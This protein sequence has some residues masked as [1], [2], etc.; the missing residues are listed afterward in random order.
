MTAGASLGAGASLLGALLVLGITLP[1]ADAHDYGWAIATAAAGAILAPVTI[2]A[3]V[4]LFGNLSGLGA[5]FGWTLLGS[6]LGLLP[7][8]ALFLVGLLANDAPSLIIIG[9]VLGGVG[10]MTGSIIAFEVSSRPG[11]GSGL[12]IGA[13]VGSLSLSGHFD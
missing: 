6:L 13:G 9:P 3:G 11:Q 1:A 8:A 5:D 4:F 2:P 10:A 7:G 12:A